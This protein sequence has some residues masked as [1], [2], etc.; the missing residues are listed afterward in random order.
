MVCSGIAWASLTDPEDSDRDKCWHTYSWGSNFPVHRP[1]ACSGSLGHRKYRLS[2]Q[3]NPM[4]SICRKPLPRISRVH[5][6]FN[7]KKAQFCICLSWDCT[8]IFRAPKSSRVIATGMLTWTV[9]RMWLAWVGVC[10]QSL[11]LLEKGATHS[12]KPDTYRP[13]IATPCSESNQG[14]I[15]PYWSQSEEQRSSQNK[16]H[17]YKISKMRNKGLHIT[18]KLF[19]NYSNKAVF[20]IS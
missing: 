20:I 12:G 13:A 2:C 10:S 18:K 4:S 7:I 11:H 16:H 17:E 3:G 14:K 6:E 8:K 19:R 15:D 1:L 5:V 9:Q